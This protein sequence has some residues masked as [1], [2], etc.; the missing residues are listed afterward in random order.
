MQIV[1]A[2]NLWKFPKMENFFSCS[3]KKVSQNGKLLAG[4]KVRKFPYM[5]TFFQE[6]IEKKFQ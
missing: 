3:L 4:T 5:T 2:V 6:K 1:E